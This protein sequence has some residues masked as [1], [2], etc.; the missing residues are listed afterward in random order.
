MNFTIRILWV[1]LLKC[2]KIFIKLLL[3][4]FITCILIFIIATA[5]KLLFADDFIKVSNLYEKYAR[6]DTSTSLVY[7]GN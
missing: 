1:I 5:F 6:F 3:I 7:E 2:H 4:E